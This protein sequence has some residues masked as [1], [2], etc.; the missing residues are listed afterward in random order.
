V[1]YWFLA[2]HLNVTYLSLAVNIGVSRIKSIM[3]LNPQL[4]QIKKGWQIANLFK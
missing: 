1:N 2:R 3:F 4:Y